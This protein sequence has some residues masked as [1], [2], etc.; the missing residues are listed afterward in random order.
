MVGLAPQRSIEKRLSARLLAAAVRFNGNKNGV[1]LCKPLR[2]VKA[3]HPAAVLFAVLEE[4][5]E[6]EWRALRRFVSSPSLK[7]GVLDAGLVVEIE[8]V[9]NERAAFG[10][11]DTTVGFAR[12]AV[13]RHVEHIGHVKLARTHELADVTIR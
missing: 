5:A 13:A 11:E 4:N 12:S 8:S 9:K 1:D 3:Q 7:C 10:I 2:I 6:I